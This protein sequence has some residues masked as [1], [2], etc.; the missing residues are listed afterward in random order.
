MTMQRTGSDVP[1]PDA[2]KVLALCGGVGGAKLVLGLNGVLRAGGLAVAVNTADDFEHLG[3][4]VSPDLDTVLY[5]LAGLSDPARGWGRAGESWNFMNALSSLGGE[6]WFAL[7][8]RDL[9][10][11]V[12]RTRRLRAGESLATIVADMA[13]RLKV[14]VRIVP[15]TDSPVRTVVHTRDGPLPFQDYFVRHR[16]APVVTAVSFAGIAEARPSPAFVDAVADPELSAIVIA[17]SNP[18]L[19]I[20]PILA[21]P[22]VREVLEGVRVPVIAVSPIIHGKAVKGPTAKIMSELGID[23]TPSAIAHHY[24]GLIDGLVIDESDAAGADQ[25]GVPVAATRTLMNDIDDKR[26]LARVVLAFAARLAGIA[27]VA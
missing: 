20:D 26:H 24:R 8:D 9:A 27:K 18:Y 17:P 4:H 12:E 7:G 15:M 5:T 13:R 22:G 11:H 16:C 1:H 21:V 3:L 23:V 6:T 19:S 10:V 25:I 14:A 2:N